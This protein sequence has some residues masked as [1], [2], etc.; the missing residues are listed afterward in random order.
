MYTLL[1]LSGGMGKRVGSTIPKQLLKLSG[2]PLLVH[3]LR[4]ADKIPQ[5]TEVVLNCPAGWETDFNTVV[6][7]YAISKPVKIVEAGVSRQDS[8]RLMLAHVRTEKVLIHEAARP[9]VRAIDFERL[10]NDPSPNVINA[11]PI[12]FTVLEKSE[13]GDEISGTLNR[14]RLVNV[15]LPQ[16][17]ATAD[18]VDAHTKAHDAKKFYTE[19]AS[20]VFDLGKPISIVPGSERNF[21]ITTPED[22]LIANLIAERGDLSNE[23]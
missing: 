20:V 5:I 18:L 11:L 23:G 7:N 14:E 2:V 8:V 21:K 17:F 19:D 3:S 1:L 22:L 4:V 16:K 10:I 6:E 9:F 13:S 15:L 12:S